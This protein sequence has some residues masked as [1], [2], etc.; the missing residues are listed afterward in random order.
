MQAVCSRPTRL[1]SSSSPLSSN[2]TPV[3]PPLPPP[4][5]SVTARLNIGLHSAKQHSSTTSSSTGSTAAI[6][7][8]DLCRHGNGNAAVVTTDTE[9]H[10]CDQS[11]SSSFFSTTSSPPPP[12]P[13]LVADNAAASVKYGELIIVGLVTMWVCVCV[14]VCAHSTVYIS[15][16]YCSF[17]VLLQYF[18][19]KSIDVNIRGFFL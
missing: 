17:Y 18:Y 16:N 9:Q 1:T 12:H 15:F 5:P 4:P 2:T 8:R 6:S 3:K 13:H 11:S 10:P 19:E 7:A 14:C